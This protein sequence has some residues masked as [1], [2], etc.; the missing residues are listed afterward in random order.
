VGDRE[1]WIVSVFNEEALRKMIEDVV[2]SVVREEMKETGHSMAA[3]PFLPVSEAARLAG[4]APGT[5]RAW[6]DDGRLGRYHAG[7]VLRVKRR[8]LEDC[9]A[10]PPPAND[11]EMSPEMRA[12]MIFRNRRTRELPPE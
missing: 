7:R 2:R 8:E 12:M 6:I 10:S 4:V 5:I 3:D 11:N 1:W 9:L